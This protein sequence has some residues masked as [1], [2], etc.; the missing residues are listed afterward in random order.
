[1]HK[2]IMTS[3]VYQQ[4]SIF[5]PASHGA[6]PDNVLLSRF[7]LRRLDA[8]TI[9]DSILKVSGRLMMEPFGPPDEVEVTP[10]GEVV[11]KG[12]KP[13]FRRSIYLL[14]RRSTPPTLL[15]LFDA[16][17]M[18]PNCLKRA[19]STV[20][21]QALQLWNSEMV[22]ESSRYLAGRV[23]DVVGEESNRQVEWIYLTALSR[24]PTGEETEEGQKALIEL[25]RYWLEHLESEVPAEPR[26]TRARWLALAAFC[27]TI[28][29]S[30]EFLYID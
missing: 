14:Q 23:I 3:V 4:R 18:D 17:R 16:P 2:L 9:R 28:L 27:H 21:T 22:R 29:N 13:G 24:W 20:P 19:H 26:A 8:E 1:M 5:D 12:S 7:P 30:P 10:E 6:D 25:T 11:S 15:E